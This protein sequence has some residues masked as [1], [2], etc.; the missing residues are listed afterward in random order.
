[1]SEP[2]FTFWSVSPKLVLERPKLERAGKRDLGDVFNPE[3][4]HET[5]LGVL[6]GTAVGQQQYAGSIWHT[7]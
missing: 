3:Y 5:R 7:I 1:M 2:V 6:Y 4:Q